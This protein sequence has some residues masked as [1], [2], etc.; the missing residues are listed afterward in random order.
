MI[1]WI[2]LLTA[3]LPL[4][5]D[6]LTVNPPGSL[7]LQVGGSG[8]LTCENFDVDGPQ[9]EW[10]DPYGDPI[11][12][13]SGGSGN[14]VYITNSIDP[15]DFH[16]VTRLHL[17]NVIVTDGGGYSCRAPGHQT[18]SRI[19]IVQEL[20]RFTRQE[21]EQN[22]RLIFNTTGTLFCTAEPRDTLEIAWSKDRDSVDPRDIKYSIVFGQLTVHNIIEADQGIYTCSAYYPNSGSTSVLD[23]NVVV[24]VP[25]TWEVA[26]GN[27][28]EV[29]GTTVVIQCR[30]RGNPPPTYTWTDRTGA[31]E[32]NITNDDPRYSLSD[33]G[34]FLTII[35]VELP[36]S[37]N[38]FVF[39]CTANNDPVG[40]KFRTSISKSFLLT[41]LVPPTLNQAVTIVVSEER[42]QTVSFQCANTQ[43]NS[44]ATLSWRRDGLEREDELFLGSQPDDSRV[45]V[46]RDDQTG[47]LTL[48]IE[49]AQRVHEG[50]WSCFAESRA[51]EFYVHHI[52]RVEY[53]PIIDQTR[54]PY[55]TI[56]WEGNPTNLTCAFLGYPNPT[57][58]WFRNNYRLNETD[59]IDFLSNLPTGVTIVHIVPQLE[60]FGAYFCEARNSEGYLRYRQ[61]LIKAAKPSRP[62]ALEVRD[63]SASTI[64]IRFYPP[65]DDGD[66]PITGY[67]VSYWIRFNVRAENYI[68]DNPYSDV[69]LCRDILA[70]PSAGAELE[71]FDSCENTL[72]ICCPFGTRRLCVDRPVTQEY[73][74]ILLVGLSAQSIYIVRVAA[75]NDLG[76]GEWTENKTV[77]T[78]VFS[79]PDMP[80]IISRPESD[81][82]DEYTLRWEPPIND[83]GLDIDRYLIA[84]SQ[85][86]GPS[87]D[88]LG[89][90]PVRM[91]A[92]GN[93]RSQ[94]LDNLNPGMFY[95]IELRAEND[96]DESDPA[97]ITMETAGNFVFLTTPKTRPEGPFGDRFVFSN[98]IIIA[99]I[100][101]V[102]LV[103]MI[104]VDLCC[105]CINDCGLLMFI[106]VTCCG[107]TPPSTKEQ[108]EMENEFSTVQDDLKDWESFDGRP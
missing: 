16:K 84:Y 79:K 41:V 73:T 17:T 107:K 12:T 54:T 81:K 104:M 92:K 28:E 105:F 67:V 96:I 29:V 66:L 43:S 27:R 78:D 5:A 52:L 90:R 45:V 93:S 82:G 106:C 13:S 68:Y 32:R 61:E 10:D 71:C 8:I 33:D 85:V 4:L 49:N 47:A 62:L 74:E 39:E 7:T 88:S 14:R 3:L 20:I 77:N 59:H 40:S 72:Q 1:V 83:G 86:D 55:R 97:V 11:Y 76:T 70:P 18:Q 99:I 6:A 65:T 15:T 87:V 57:L 25:P 44:E 100:F 75:M 102:L 80:T 30:A 46:T 51:G 23:I 48:T 36:Q 95:R 101:V 9:P 19:V 108:I 42:P 103:F 26:P 98:R 69:D 60:D 56:S 91:T 31:V 53:A 2:T 50:Q 21:E 63:V 35:N 24:Q 94:V 37:G 38:I 58:R 89:P 22:Q 64:K 34:E